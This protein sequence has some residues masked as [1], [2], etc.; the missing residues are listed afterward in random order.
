MAADVAGDDVAA[1]D[2]AADAVAE[3]EAPAE[4]GVAAWLGG[5]GGATMTSRTYPAPRS[6]AASC[7][8]LGLG[9]PD[10]RPERAR[11]STVPVSDRRGRGRRG[12]AGDAGVPARRAAPAC[13]SA[14]WT[15]RAAGPQP[16]RSTGRSWRRLPVGRRSR[17]IRQ[18]RRQRLRRRG[19]PEARPWPA[20]RSRAAIRERNAATRSWTSPGATTGS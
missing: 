13:R 20:A 4:P 16:R 2:A 3:R 8:R 14:G 1:A 17:A 5:R 10:R 12:R 15:S 9:Q 11:S 7:L 19:C 6:P 18:V